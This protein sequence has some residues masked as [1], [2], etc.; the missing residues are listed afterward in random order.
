VK[1]QEVL[2]KRRGGTRGEEER[3]KAERSL[4]SSV[5]YLSISP[6]LSLFVSVRITNGEGIIE[7]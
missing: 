3:R 6:S 4:E 5:S 1:Y 2:G 7:I